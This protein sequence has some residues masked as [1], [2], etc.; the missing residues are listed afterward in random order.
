MVARLDP[1][2]I[3]SFDYKRREGKGHLVFSKCVLLETHEADIY[4]HTTSPKILPHVAM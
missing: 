4:V 1:F 3:F 2:F